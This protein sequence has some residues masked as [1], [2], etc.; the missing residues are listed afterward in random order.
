MYNN[1]IVVKEFIMRKLASI[2]T[3]DSID[4]IE[5][6]DAIEVATVG[7]WKIVVKKGEFA[8]GDLAVYLEIDSWVPT[9]L[10]P[11]LSKGKEPRE[12]EGIKGERLRTVKLRG[13]LSQGLLLPLSEV[14]KFGPDQDVGFHVPVTW[15][16]GED[17]TEALGIKKWERPM[18]AQLA[19]M[20]RGNFPSLIPKTDQERI[21]NLKKEIANAAAAGMQFE[22]T[23]KLEGSSMTV[24]LIDGVF[25][26]C[27][28]NLDLKE[29]EGNAFW[30]T[31]RELDIEGKMREI[32]DGEWAIQGELIG[33]GIQNNIYK[34]SKTEFHVFDVYNIKSGEYLTPVFRRALIERMGLTHVP[35]LLVD[36][37]L[38]VGSVDE[39][40][41][42]AEGASKLND[43][44]ER[45]GIVFKEVNGGMTF[46]AISNLYLMNEK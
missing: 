28:R 8:V 4:P 2:R 7:G 33:P 3:I 11:F 19:G 39:I 9:E 43:K 23:E 14:T 22:V 29:T 20:A 27:S 25:G 10:A 40:L 32:P 13:Q 16:E 17:V 18:N 26:V 24:Y 45:E 12:F 37:D 30:A 38:G 41:Q 6:A 21:Q 5:G 35:V 46:K 15:A 44:V 42:W 36:K 31:A 34:L 1:C